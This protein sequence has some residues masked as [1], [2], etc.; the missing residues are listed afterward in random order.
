MLDIS[1]DNIRYSNKNKKMK[2]LNQI[3]ILQKNFL[4]FLIYDSSPKFLIY[5]INSFKSN[6]I[7][8]NDYKTKYS[9]TNG[10]INKEKN[11]NLNN[12]NKLIFKNYTNRELGKA[13][14]L[15]SFKNNKA[16]NPHKSS[17]NSKNINIK[18]IYML[19]EVGPNIQ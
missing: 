7:L 2:N 12:K 4:I 6:K 15:A 11:L 5:P 17:I 14:K 3:I 13:F 18:E 16:F 9:N 1:K 19:R 10:N 8:P